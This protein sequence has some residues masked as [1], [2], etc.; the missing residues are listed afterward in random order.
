M[1]TI[2]NVVLNLQHGGRGSSTDP[3]SP[4]TATVSFTTRFNSTELLARAV[5]KAKVIIRSDDSTTQTIPIQNV[6]I[7]ATA[8]SVLTTVSKVLRRIQLDEDID[9]IPNPDPPP[10]SLPYPMTDEWQAVVTLSPMEF[11]SAVATSEI[12]E[13]SWGRKGNS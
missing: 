8:S 12:V 13:G 11:G 9:L 10:P 1:P 3:D 4:R 6:V 5:F 7:Q 2:S